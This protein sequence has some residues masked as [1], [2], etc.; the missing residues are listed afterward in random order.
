MDHSGDAAR[1]AGADAS[2]M[3]GRGGLRRGELEGEP[4]IELVWAV[5]SS[6][7][8]RGLATTAA[9]ESLHAAEELNL[10]NVIA[11]IESANSASCR[12][13]ERAGLSL[14]RDLPYDGRPHHLYRPA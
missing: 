2:A 14:D 13:A 6:H 4:V 8:G 11:L 5:A 12:V 10:S 3:V 7:Q 9:T 1:G